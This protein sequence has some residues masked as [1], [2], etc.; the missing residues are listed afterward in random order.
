VGSDDLCTTL[1]EINR[2]K[3]PDC[4]EGEYIVSDNMYKA[5]YIAMGVEN[6][7]IQKLAGTF[8]VA[9]KLGSAL[10]GAWQVEKY[11]QLP[12]SQNLL[13]SRIKRDLDRFVEEKF[14][15]DGKVCV[16]DIY[17]HL[18]AAPYGFMPCN[19]SAFI[20]GFLLKE[21]VDCGYNWSDEITS[22]KFG[23]DKLKESV[24]AVIKQQITPSNRFRPSYIVKTTAEQKAFYETTAKAFD[25]P[26]SSC[27]SIENA[28]ELVRGQIKSM[29]FPIW[30]LKWL[31][32]LED[33][34]DVKKLIELYCELANNKNAV[35]AKSDS[36]IVNEIGKL[37]MRHPEAV[38]SLKAV[39]NKDKCTDGMSQYVA[40]YREGELSELAKEVADDGQ[41]INVL[42][43]KFDAEDANWVWN[44]QTAQE[45]IDEVIVE[46]KI[47][48]ESNKLLTPKCCSLDKTVQGWID[49]CDNIKISCDAGKNRFGGIA[50]F[51]EMLSQLCKTE[52]IADASKEKFLELLEKHLDSFNKFYNN[53]NPLF[54]KLCGH[55]FVNKNLADSDIKEIMKQIDNG[56]FTAESMAYL[57]HVTNVTEKYVA[58]LAS[59]RL[60]A[61]WREKTNT[62][63]PR[64]WSDMHKMPVWWLVPP[65]EIQQAKEAFAIINGDNNGVSSAVEKAIEY[66]EKATFF[67]DMKNTVAQDEAFTRCVIGKYA[68]L[69]NNIDE[70]KILLEAKIPA[71]SPY[72]WT[73]FNALIQDEVKAFAEREYARSGAKAA[74][75][76]IDKLPEADVK[77]YLKQLIQDNINVGVEIL[78]SR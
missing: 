73:D 37:V 78:K 57:K 2:D 48:R 1:K 54:I 14:D 24:E 43:G 67:N 28:R 63:S 34:D 32:E 62:D 5:N 40:R 23:I 49:L 47:I 39:L 17:D 20:I 52:E 12:Q 45:R 3:Y 31:P 72:N 66:I 68:P 59:T 26:D 60:K 53:Q 15:A 44:E 7:A 69:L 58:N 10:E 61:L 19:L 27:V 21:Y 35:T 76:K 70:V 55:L 42:R 29:S 41:Y 51:M 9:S 75:E 25:V 46:Y 38:D 11:W 50:P 33:K 77:K 6:G 74:L 16:G 65:A 56:V 18:R 13:I 22:D 64:K 4:L 8:N 30:T 36:D 71:D